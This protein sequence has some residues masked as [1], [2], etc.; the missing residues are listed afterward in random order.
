[1][2]SGRGV[3]AVTP[4]LPARGGVPGPRR[5]EVHTCANAVGAG[6]RPEKV[7]GSGGL[8]SGLLVHMAWAVH[9]RPGA[10]PPS[11]GLQFTFLPRPRPH[12]PALTSH[13]GCGGCKS[14]VSAPW[15]GLN[16]R[17]LP[18][19]VGRLRVQ[20]EVLAGW[21]LLGP[22]SWAHGCR[23]VPCPHL[24]IPLCARTQSYGIGATLQPL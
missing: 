8:P 11:L 7:R 17:P 13:M 6:G 18:L 15:G 10:Y 14:Q 19:G 22:P 9:P 3:G 5:H 2:P 16:S 12:L 21:F 24:V 4:R 1:M 23:P 20:E